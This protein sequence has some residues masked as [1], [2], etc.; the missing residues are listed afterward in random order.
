M[1]HFLNMHFEFFWDW[2]FPTSKL[3]SPRSILKRVS[4][5]LQVMN[6]QYR[7]LHHGTVIH[8]F[9]WN[10]QFWGRSKN[11]CRLNGL[12]NFTS[13]NCFCRMCSSLYTWNI[14]Y[15]AIFFAMASMYCIFTF[16][17]IY[18]KIQPN[19]GRYTARPMDISVWDATTWWFGEISPLPVET[20]G[21]GCP[22]CDLGLETLRDEWFV[23]AGS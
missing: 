6:L 7:W 11:P 3:G 9:S 22:R 19:A 2:N 4:G 1:W 17:Y 15:L 10:Y 8:H 16:T 20:R 21:L 14:L 23:D 12:F 13:W 18:H 5:S